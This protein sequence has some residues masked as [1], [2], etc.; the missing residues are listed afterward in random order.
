MSTLSDKIQLSSSKRKKVDLDIAPVSAGSAEFLIPSSID[1][2]A[3]TCITVSAAHFG[4]PPVV[5]PSSQQLASD[6][7][8]LTLLDDEGVVKKVSTSPDEPIRFRLPPLTNT[9]VDAPIV[10]ASFDVER[11]QF[12]TD[13]CV[14]WGTDASG[15]IVCECNHLTTFG[16]LFDGG[17]EGGGGG[18]RTKVSLPDV[19]EITDFG[20]F[21][22]GFDVERY[23]SEDELNS[24][25]QLASGFTGEIGDTLA[26]AAFSSD[27]V[28]NQPPGIQYLVCLDV[29]P[30]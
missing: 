25:G 6:V 14:L 13:G 24:Q 23:F 21:N 22:T 26:E 15:G 12:V 7:G 3:T 27:F 16:A 18:G 1:L 8:A 17:G 10:C 4:A 29:C 11:Q 30:C 2:E 9:F 28:L 5:V 19:S 20:D